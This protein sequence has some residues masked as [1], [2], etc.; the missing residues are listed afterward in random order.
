MLATL[1]ANYCIDPTR[2]YAAGFSWGCDHATALACCRGNKVRAIAAAS[3][4][5]EFVNPANYQ[6][7]ANLPCPVSKT[8]AIRFTHAV[9]GDS[10][11]PSPLFASTS[12]LYRAFAGCAATSTATSPAPCRSYDSC[13][14]PY[15]ECAYPNLGHSIPAGWP[16]DSWTFFSRLPAPPTTTPAPV[17]TLTRPSLALLGLL[18]LCGAFFRS[19]LTK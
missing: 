4:S 19:A 6:S 17:P 2:V 10:A 9:D 12:A 8:T 1:S 13:S 5:D 16:D 14:Q 18:L 15:V 11:L 7:Y 3:C